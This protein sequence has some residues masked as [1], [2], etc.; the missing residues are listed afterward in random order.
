MEMN[1][2]RGNKW[3]GMEM[4]KQIFIPKAAPFELRFWFEIKEQV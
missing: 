3:N 4:E 2:D 1:R